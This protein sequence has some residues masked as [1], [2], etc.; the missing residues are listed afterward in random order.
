MKWSE[1]QKAADVEAE[2]LKKKKRDEKWK[3]G[4]A[5]SCSYGVVIN[6]PEFNKRK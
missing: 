6:H 5:F 2:D 3:K 1:I 4:C